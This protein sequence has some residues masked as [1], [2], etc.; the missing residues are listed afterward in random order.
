MK[1]YSEIIIIGMNDQMSK[2]LEQT[3]IVFREAY[4]RMVKKLCIRFRYYKKYDNLPVGFRRD[5]KYISENAMF[6]AI[7]DNPSVYKPWKKCV[8]RNLY[9]QALYLTNLFRTGYKEKHIREFILPEAFKD[10]LSINPNDLIVN[11][12]LTTAEIPMLGTIKFLTPSLIPSSDL[13]YTM[14]IGKRYSEDEFYLQW[15]LYY[16]QT[17]VVEKDKDEEDEEV[18]DDGSV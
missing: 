5:L 7:V 8:R 4:P 17:T 10:S 18:D 11:D 12:D 15:Y 14:R 3:L 6:E 2:R 1:R 16:E 9:N 13:L